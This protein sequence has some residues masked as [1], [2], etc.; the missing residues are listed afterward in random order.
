MLQEIT[1]LP[2]T[3]ENEMDCK[4]MLDLASSQMK[5]CRE[6]YF[7]NDPC[8]TIIVRNYLKPQ[9]TKQSDSNLSGLYFH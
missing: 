6:T 5:P 1:F 7:L 8:I 2:N 9:K 3:T 4:D